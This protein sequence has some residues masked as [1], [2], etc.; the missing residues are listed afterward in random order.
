MAGTSKNSETADDATQLAGSSGFVGSDMFNDEFVFTD[1]DGPWNEQA[2]H[3]T[4]NNQDQDQ[5]EGMDNLVSDM[6]TFGSLGMDQQLFGNQHDGNRQAPG[7]FSDPFLNYNQPPGLSIAPRNFNV[8]DNENGNSDGDENYQLFFKEMVDSGFTEEDNA[9]QGQSA[10][11]GFGGQADEVGNTS[12]GFTPPSV[13]NNSQPRSQVNAELEDVFA[14]DEQFGMLQFQQQHRVTQLQTGQFNLQ[15]PP[16]FARNISTQSKLATEDGLIDP[17]LRTSNTQNMSGPRTIPQASPTGFSARR[18]QHV[19]RK[20][21]SNNKSN[22]PPEQAIDTGG[23][24]GR[25]NKR[26]RVT[27]GANKAQG[28]QR[29]ALHFSQ[30]PSLG[31]V[32]EQLVLRSDRVDAQGGKVFGAQPQSMTHF[33]S[34]LR[35][36]PRMANQQIAAPRKPGL[37]K[38]G[39][40]MFQLQANHPPPPQTFN[41]F[42]NQSFDTPSHID[43][44]GPTPMFNPDRL[45][46]PP[47]VIVGPQVAPAVPSPITPS[48]RFPFDVFKYPTGEHYTKYLGPQVIKV[49]YENFYQDVTGILHAN[50]GKLPPTTLI[51]TAVHYFK[52]MNWDNQVQLNMIYLITI[53]HNSQQTDL[54]QWLWEVFRAASMIQ[55]INCQSPMVLALIETIKW[56]IIRLT[57]LLLKNDMTEFST[58]ESPIFGRKVGPATWTVQHQRTTIWEVLNIHE[59]KEEPGL[60]VRNFTQMVNAK[61]LQAGINPDES[62]LSLPQAEDGEGFI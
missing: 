35:P 2:G 54:H 9:M 11:M 1:N 49:L 48:L 53:L 51:D 26:L 62:P 56:Q 4:N 19:A 21:K 15:E 33:T 45:Q 41:A 22:S 3:N 34:I 59:V 20:D 25:V 29:G 8:D 6:N 32:P 28:G 47:S 52:M 36:Q 58:R 60:W 13:L 40:G 23:K 16:R 10:L 30:T 61:F 57:L 44:F 55:K 7:T 18:R 24:D 50:L 14:G 43:V 17:E 31:K 37:D 46:G 5:D 39:M 27:V 42:N 38:P 12:E